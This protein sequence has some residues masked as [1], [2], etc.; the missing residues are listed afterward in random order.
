M[1]LPACS[2]RWMGW[3]RH[4]GLMCPILVCFAGLCMYLHT[5]HT[6]KATEHKEVRE[7]HAA[8]DREAWVGSGRMAWHSGMHYTGVGGALRPSPPLV[9]MAPQSPPPHG[10]SAPHCMAHSLPG[11]AHT[12]WDQG[13]PPKCSDHRHHTAKALPTGSPGGQPH[14]PKH[15]YPTLVPQG[16]QASHQASN[17]KAGWPRTPTRVWIARKSEQLHR[18]KRGTATHPCAH[19]Q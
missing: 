12:V 9:C 5:R 3:V 17:L 16:E 15:K 2:H 7:L 14:T 19:S 18:C 1:Q 10:L 4:V 8:I 11:Q 6:S 13:R